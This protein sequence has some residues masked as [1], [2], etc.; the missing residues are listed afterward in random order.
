MS[1]QSNNGGE[2]PSFSKEGDGVS[3]QLG[4]PSA[5]GG[6]ETNTADGD[7]VKTS[8]EA[9]NAM[10][11]QTKRRSVVIKWLAVG[12]RRSKCRLVI[13]IPELTCK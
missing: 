5:G 1:K 8:G 12:N 9:D 2:G 3:K 4:E 11:R 7:D 13:K 10:G 6:W